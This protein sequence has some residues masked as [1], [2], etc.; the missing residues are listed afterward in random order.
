MLTYFQYSEIPDQVSEL[1]SLKYDLG[2]NFIVIG[3]KP[4]TLQHLIILNAVK[5]CFKSEGIIEKIGSKSLPARYNWYDIENDVA[6]MI[7]TSKVPILFYGEFRQ[8]IHFVGNEI[9]EFLFKLKNGKMNVIFLK[10]LVFTW[11]GT[12]NS[13]ETVLHILNDEEVCND[14]KLKIALKYFAGKKQI[15]KCLETIGCSD[16]KKWAENKDIRDELQIPIYF[17]NWIINEDQDSFKMLQKLKKDHDSIGNRRKKV[18][19][20]DYSKLCYRYNSLFLSYLSDSEDE[21][22]TLPEDFTS[23]SDD[24]MRDDENDLQRELTKIISTSFNN[25]LLK[26]EINKLCED[27]YHYADEPEIRRN[28]SEEEDLI[29]NFVFSSMLDNYNEMAVHYLWNNISCIRGKTI[30]HLEKLVQIERIDF[31]FLNMTMFMFTNCLFLATDT[32]IYSFYIVRAIIKN[33][34]WSKQFLRYCKL[35]MLHFSTNNH[36]WFLFIA[37]KN[38]YKDL[39]RKRSD[40]FNKY[41]LKKY[42][43][44]IPCYYKRQI[45]LSLGGHYIYKLLDMAFNPGDLELCKLL[46]SGFEDENISEYLA[47][48]G[49]SLFWRPFHY[50]DFSFIEGIIKELKLSEK[51]ILKLKIDIFKKMAYLK[52]ESLIIRKEYKLV[53]S[54]VTWSSEFS[55]E[56]DVKIE[57]LK[58]SYGDGRKVI[59]ELLFKN[60]K[61]FERFVQLD[62]FLSWCFSED[63]E[64]I[65]KFKKEILSVEESQTNFYLDIREWIENSRWDF[66]EKLFSWSGCNDEEMVP[67]KHML[68]NDIFMDNIFTSEGGGSMFLNKFA[69]YCNTSISD[70]REFDSK[71]LKH[72]LYFLK[73]IRNHEFDLIDEIITWCKPEISQVVALKNNLLISSIDYLAFEESKFSEENFDDYVKWFQPS[74]LTKKKIMKMSVRYFKNSS[75]VDK[76]IR[77]IEGFDPQHV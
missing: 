32:I 10:N 55:L 19:C 13:I 64:K 74:F 11:Q 44:M 17:W 70:R 69:Y 36:L 30:D 57:K 29:L 2:R 37:V 33:L 23:E 50:L 5:T 45:K 9:F 39:M 65:S 22:S 71:I 31:K 60:S 15:K 67:L 40:T 27:E 59:G 47:K 18:H 66:L 21:E 35:Y 42:L 77:S 61:E 68:M 46:I 4:F 48:E 73:L 38:V 49:I 54:I 51:D 3:E 75:R 6:E 16:I 20:Q 41:L 43:T 56:N 58:F 28:F 34:R 52:I 14:D 72:N 7:L 53:N 12:I 8:V 62:E 26:K 63:Q 1:I 76:L 25:V 24:E